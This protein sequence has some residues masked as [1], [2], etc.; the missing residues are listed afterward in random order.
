M[1]LCGCDIG[2][3][4]V[5]QILAQKLESL[6]SRYHRRRSCQNI[7]NPD[8]LNVISLHTPYVIRGGGQTKLPQ[9]AK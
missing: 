6:V 8:V 7:N 1:G 4:Y 5:Y 2:S 3:G 9:T